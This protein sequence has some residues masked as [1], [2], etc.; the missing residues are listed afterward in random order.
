MD[1]KNNPVPGTEEYFP[2]DTLLLSCG[3]IPEN[4]LSRSAGVALSPLTNGP[5]VDESLETDIEGVFACGNVLHVHD[6]VDFVSEEAVRAGRN[7]AEY[8]KGKPANP[9][10]P[11]EVIPCNGVR[12]TVPSRLYTQS[13]TEGVHIRFRVTGVYKGASIVVK[14][15]DDE[16]FRR[17]GRI[18]V[19]SEMLD[20]VIKPEKLTGVT[21]RITVEIEEGAK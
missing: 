12:Y 3:L 6:L 11:V 5:Y 17:K 9:G 20:V 16:L 13:V 1:E 21:G 10:E 4:E 8:I 19:P 14:C 7:A 15:G 18:F 2:C